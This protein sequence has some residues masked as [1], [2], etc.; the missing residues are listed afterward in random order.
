[1]YVAAEVE[2]LVSQET[3]KEQAHQ[4]RRLSLDLHANTTQ[5]QAA[6]LDN[7]LSLLS[8]FRLSVCHMHTRA[9]SSLGS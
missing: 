7:F 4:M 2:S 1:M 3:I 6:V 5:R 8:F 9:P